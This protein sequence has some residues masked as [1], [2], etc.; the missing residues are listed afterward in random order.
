MSLRSHLVPLSVA[1][2]LGVAAGL[3]VPHV[4]GAGVALPAHAA[5]TP[6]NHP[7]LAEDGEPILTEAQRARLAE[8]HAAL[9]AA[10]PFYGQEAP[11]DCYEDMVCWIGTAHDGRD[12][13]S[14]I[15]DLP[16]DIE[17]AEAAYPDEG[18]GWD[19]VTQQYADVLAE[20]LGDGDD[21]RQWESCWIRVADTTVVV[22]PDGTVVTS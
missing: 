19:H 22:C 15:A 2:A 21:T 13:D 1:A 18:T 14:I 3:A 4:Y 11:A 16:H 5:V 10:L 20:G 8:R 7:A 12:D 9:I 6:G 17:A